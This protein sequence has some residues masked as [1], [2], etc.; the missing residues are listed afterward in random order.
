MLMSIPAPAKTAPESRSLNARIMV[1]EDDS[2]LAD[3]LARVLEG[4]GFLVDV[5]AE[6]A[7]ADA[8]LASETYNLVLLDIGLPDLQRDL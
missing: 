4:Q 7:K 3:G 6:G 5:F 8:A 2:V 1:V